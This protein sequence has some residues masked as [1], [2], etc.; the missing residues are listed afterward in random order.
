VAFEID[1]TPRPGGLAVVLRGE[2]DVATAP[3]LDAAVDDRG[4]DVRDLVVDLRELTFLDSTGLRSLLRARSVA[5]TAGGTLV[6]VPGPPAV[7]RAFD[8]TG[9]TEQF[10][11]ERS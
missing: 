10:R 1:L 9:L 4:G 8:L 3:Q 2:L 7:Q 6:L 11:W 5:D